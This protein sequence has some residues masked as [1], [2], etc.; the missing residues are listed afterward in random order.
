ML[1]GPINIDKVLRAHTRFKRL[2]HS[3]FDREVEKVGKFGVNYVKTNPTF[4]PR[5]G[6]LQKQTDYRVLVLKSGAVVRISNSS[7]YGK[8]VEFGTRRHMIAARRAR[9]LTFTW[10][11]VLVHRRYVMHPGTRP[12]KFLYRAAS[13]AGRAFV[14]SMDSGMTRIAKQF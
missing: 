7:K 2:H 1:D 8:W 9:A 11:G 5:T 14:P 6:F 3:L 4:K 10:K 12:Y 13:A